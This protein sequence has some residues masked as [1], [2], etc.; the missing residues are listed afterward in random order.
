MDTPIHPNQALIDNL[1]P[2]QYSPAQF[3]ASTSPEPQ[4]P[5]VSVTSLPTVHPMSIDTNAFDSMLSTT[6]FQSLGDSPMIP[7]ISGVPLVQLSGQI[8][9]PDTRTV[10]DPSSQRMTVHMDS[11][12]PDLCSKTFSAIDQMK[13]KFGGWACITP[14]LPKGLL[15]WDGPFLV[16][17]LCPEVASLAADGIK[18]VENL[19][20][21]HWVSFGVQGY[22]VSL[23]KQGR[24]LGKVADYIPSQYHKRRI[25]KADGCKITSIQMWSAP[26]TPTQEE[27]TDH[28]YQPKAP[29]GGASSMHRTLWNHRHSLAEG[30][31]TH[32]EARWRATK[33]SSRDICASHH[34]TNELQERNL[35]LEDS[36][37][38]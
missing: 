14:W 29:K 15:Q 17:I 20:I 3:F 26:C 27:I 11:Q 6:G 25:S 32:L 22:I 35:G 5:S 12:Q 33:I 7:I 16:R 31:A 38:G 23:I 19:D 18:R 9:L 24:L 4:N 37:T 2:I 13:I 30:L 34:T 36:R 8:S 10:G 1:S 28:W 21:K